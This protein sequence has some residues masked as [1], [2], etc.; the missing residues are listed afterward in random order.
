MSDDLIDL[1]IV[2]KQI[3][4]FSFTLKNQWC[5]TLSCGVIFLQLFIIQLL[6]SVDFHGAEKC[7]IIHFL[8]ANNVHS[9]LPWSFGSY[10]HKSVVIG[11]W[12]FLALTFIIPVF[13]QPIRTEE[14]RGQI[15][16]IIREISE[17]LGITIFELTSDSR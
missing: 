16:T 17:K 3:N 8:Q 14:F 1:K 9:K 5:V 6:Q 2:I 13:I 10:I 12:L 4:F 7:Y 11:S 15:S